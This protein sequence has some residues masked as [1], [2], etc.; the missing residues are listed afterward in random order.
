MLCA[1]VVPG[2]LQRAFLYLMALAA[3]G[4]VWTREC[5]EVEVVA[6]WCCRAA[7]MGNS[8]V[9]RK[10]GVLSRRSITV[11]YYSYQKDVWQT[12]YW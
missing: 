9:C 1:Y 12:D 5:G 10:T 3:Y 7:A 11:H 4:Q 6:A 2:D 8:D